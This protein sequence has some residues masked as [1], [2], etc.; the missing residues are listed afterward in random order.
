M[1]LKRSLQFLLVLLALTGLAAN[2]HA[3]AKPFASERS[4]TFDIRVGSLSLGKATLEIEKKQRKKRRIRVHAKINLL[5]GG[6]MGVSTKST[7]WV[8]N[9]WKPIRSKWNWQSFGKKRHVDAKYGAKFFDGRIFF[10]PKLHKRMSGKT[11]TSKQRINDL[12]SVVP[13]LMNQRIRTGRILR[14]RAYT[15]LQIY[16]ITAK[17]GKIETLTV[18]GLERRVYPM[19]ITAVRPGKTRRMTLWLDAVNFAPCKATVDLDFVSKVSLVLTKL[20][21]AKLAI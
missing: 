21:Q 5:G 13:W 12:I 20:K 2:A 10:G 6:A 18:M 9:S 19:Y 15:G 17:V 8:D 3:K 7:T 4:Y 14:T 1:N 16:R 11:R